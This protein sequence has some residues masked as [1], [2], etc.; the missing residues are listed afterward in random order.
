MA[1]RLMQKLSEARD[2]LPTS[3][4]IIGVHDPGEHPTF[5]GGFPDVYRASYD[6]KRAALKR[7]RTFTA[8]S[9]NPKRMVSFS[10]HIQFCKEALVWQGLRHA[11]ILPFLDI[12]R[13]TFP[14]S[15]CMVSPWLKH[16][17]ILKYLN[18]RGREDIHRLIFEIAQ[19]FHYLHSVNI[20]HGDLRGTN[21]LISDDYHACLSDFGLATTIR[22]GDADTTAGALASSSNRTGSLRWF[23]ELI[24]PEQFGCERFVRTRATDVYAFGCVCL[25][26]E[27]GALPFAD[28]PDVPAMFNVLAGERPEQ[29][30][31]MSDMISYLANAA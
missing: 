25:E 18:D 15:F 16:G 21:I 23:A 1:C 17:T 10:I 29:P 20:V 31:T 12:D 13:H 4:F 26:L 6:S 9:T 22:E 30:D 5:A 24:T 2:Q 28:V 14:S 11:S 8:D 7:I 19:G 3:L 27:T